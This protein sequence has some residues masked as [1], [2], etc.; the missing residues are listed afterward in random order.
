MANSLSDRAFELL[1]IHGP[2]LVEEWAELLVSQGLDR[3][4]AW[5][6]LEG[7]ANPALGMLP[8]GRSIALDELIEGRVLTHRLSATEIASG[9][10]AVGTDLGAMLFT[11]AETIEGLGGARAGFADPEAEIVDS[12]GLDNDIDEVLIMEPSALAEFPPGTL[13]GVEIV[14][15]APRL[16]VVGETV[17]VPDLAAGLTAHVPA[18]SAL[19]VDELV[20]GL[21]FADPALFTAAA[22]PVSELLS[23]AGF[24]VRGI[25]VARAGFDWD[26]FDAETAMHLITERYELD[27]EQARAVWTFGLLVRVLGNMPPGRREDFLSES[28]P[29]V[30]SALAKPEA[31]TA[32]FEEAS[33]DPD[34]DATAALAAAKYLLRNNP[35]ALTAAA[36]WLAGK[37]AEQADLLSDAERHLEDATTADPLWEPATMDLARYAIDRG[38]L[39]RAISLLDRT[40]EGPLTQAY[41]LIRAAMPDEHP[42]LG[43]NDR[44]WCGSGRKYKNCHLGKT[45]LSILDRAQLLYLK[46][47]THCDQLDLWPIRADLAAWRA[48]PDATDAELVAALDDPLVMD[49]MLFE[50]GG[51]DDFLERRGELLPEADLLLAQGWQRA[52]RSVFAI[53]AIGSGDTVVLRDLRSGERHEVPAAAA[54]SV[55]L[56]A[57]YCAHLVPVGEHML[58]TGPL[59]PV[60]PAKSDQLVELLDSDTDGGEIIEFLST[61]E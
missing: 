14:A 38:D 33:A 27:G 47:V 20:W 17:V 26:A 60:S 3:E 48:G 2:L 24:T 31:A 40:E 4:Q 13:I 44:C 16:R 23:A 52:P 43:R 57:S 58:F 29:T 12:L 6:L 9:A 59:E 53:E 61:A 41:A 55:Q 49:V 15:G 32:A 36:H 11:D 54:G 19:E 51:F 35:R 25:H 46:A 8:D 21:M 28:N 1:R 39:S 30:L 37:A 50:C 22:P 45:D 18:D 7:C 56:G 34:F 5:D 10:I 42:D